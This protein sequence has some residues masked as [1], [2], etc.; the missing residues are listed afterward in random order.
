[1]E[2]NKKNLEKN[3]RKGASKPIP[4]SITTIALNT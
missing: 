2:K 3:G 1:V 4:K